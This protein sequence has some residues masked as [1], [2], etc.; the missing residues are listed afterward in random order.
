VLA[1]MGGA[2][3]VGLGAVAT[4]LLGRIFDLS[5]H[6]TLGYVAMSLAVSSIVGIAS[7]WYPAARAAKMDRWWRFVR[8]ER[9]HQRS[10]EHARGRG[11]GVDPP[12]PVAAHHSGHRDRITTVVT[13]ASLLT[14]LRQ[15]W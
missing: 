8:S 3:G 2:C 10:G 4:M 14:G 6:I 9:E 5:L 15:G 7:G 11:G 12:V 1:T 13:V